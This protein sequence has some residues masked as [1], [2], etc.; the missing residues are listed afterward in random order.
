MKNH[1]IAMSIIGVI[2]LTT[3]SVYAN[4]FIYNPKTYEWKAINANGSV[5]R[6]GHGSGGKSYCADIK[7]SC[8]TPTGVYHIRSK[9]DATCRSSRYPVGRGGAPMPYC[10]FFSDYYA[11]HGSNDVPRRNASH[12]CVRVTPGDAKW[13]SHDF[14]KIGTKVVIKP[15]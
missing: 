10:M 13:L 6:T 3:T 8:R 1:L 5:V 15:Y 11:I 14:I 2:S 7:R 9:G 4:E 12:G